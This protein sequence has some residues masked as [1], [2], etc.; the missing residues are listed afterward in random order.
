MA[1]YRLLLYIAFC[2][3][4][5]ACTNVELGPVNGGETLPVP[6]LSKITFAEDAG[7]HFTVS[8]T[9]TSVEPNTILRITN[10]RLSVRQLAAA[11]ES[12]AFAVMLVSA[13]IGDHLLLESIATD[14]TSGAAE[15][16]LAFP[17]GTRPPEPSSLTAT[18]TAPADVNVT[19]AGIF[20]AETRPI[21]VRVST[22]ASG[23]V[24]QVPTTF[25]AEGRAFSVE[26]PAFHGDTLLIY[27]V[28]TPTGLTGPFAQ[29][30]ID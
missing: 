20:F 30:G 26:L 4:V 21:E 5:S 15:M 12:G 1:N 29:M 19:V 14:N 25:S 7:A 28:D 8:G 16:L 27:G 18:R 17:A 9:N 24:V 22:L 2:A 6:D 11:S 23:S 10:L 3:A 13:A